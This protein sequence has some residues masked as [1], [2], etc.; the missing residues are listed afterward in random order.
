MVSTLDFESS[1]PGSNPGR[2]SLSF[3]PLSLYSTG[4][5]LLW[6]KANQPSV[7]LLTIPA[8]YKLRTAHIIL[9][10]IA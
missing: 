10:R 4:V 3:F 2:T 6:R 8:V 7:L 1:D 9:P 5:L